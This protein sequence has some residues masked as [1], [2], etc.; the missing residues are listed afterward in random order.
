[1]AGRSMT[2]HGEQG[3]VRGA[4]STRPGVQLRTLCLVVVLALVAAAC[5]LR[6]P[7]ESGAFAGGSRVDAGSVAGGPGDPAAASSVGGAEG[8]AGPGSAAAAGGSDRA[9]P[10]GGGSA[11]A[12]GGGGDTITVGGIHHRTGALDIFGIY[13]GTAAYFNALNARGGINGRKVRF[14]DYDDGQ[15]AQRAAEVARRLVEQ[16][17]VTF[18]VSGAD[19]TNDAIAEYTKRK[20]I[21]VFGGSGTANAWFKYDNWFPPVANQY[22]LFPGVLLQ[23]AKAK[24]RSKVA[25]LYIGLAQGAQ[26]AEAAKR[27]AAHYGMELVYEASFSPV[28]PDFTPYVVRARSAGADVVFFMGTYDQIVRLKRAEV[29]QRYDPMNLLPFT[30]R[31]DLVKEVGADAMA[32]DLMAVDHYSGFVAPPALWADLRAAMDKYFP[33]T[34]QNGATAAG[35]YSAALVGEVLRRH[36][37]GP[38]TSASVLS[39]A[40]GIA[41]WDGGGI[42]PPVD[43]RP[44]SPFRTGK[45]GCD[46]L[47]EFGP[48]GSLRI[49]GP[50]FTC[51][52]GA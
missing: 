36:P 18:I 42:I 15:D 37:A 22:N 27:Y 8:V 26:I 4:S 2:I 35:W 45:S 7:E 46:Q 13:E 3:G 20:G 28:E 9:R 23:G 43:L 33:N 47:L 30:A 14:I 6:V 41:G 1:M 24:G 48:D 52:E 16:D 34:P 21:P 49:V 39:T 31:P 25:V 38:V 5:G 17:R 29:Q 40:A 44:G 51:V 11:A 12:T 10:G 19:A 32:G 50:T